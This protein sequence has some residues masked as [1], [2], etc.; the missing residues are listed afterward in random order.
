[1]HVVALSGKTVQLGFGPGVTRE[2]IHV[3]L[4]TLFAI[5]GCLA[6]GLLGFDAHLYG[7]NPDPVVAEIIAAEK[8]EGVHYVDI[9]AKVGL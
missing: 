8:F 9:R 7:V 3:A 2:S 6:C 1:V 4:D 5:S